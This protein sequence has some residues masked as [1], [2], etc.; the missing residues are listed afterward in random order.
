MSSPRLTA[1]VILAL[2]L[3]LMAPRALDA[4]ST[5]GVHTVTVVGMKFVPDKLE[6]H[7]GDTI[8]WKNDD[9]V[10]HTVTATDKSFDS[11]AIISGKSWHHVVQKKGRLAY[12][13]TFHPTMKG[14]LVVKEP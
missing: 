11:G 14:T 5:H 8:V 9:I 1:R 6:V 12:S 13:C 3:L 2:S 7:P 10:P 4:Q